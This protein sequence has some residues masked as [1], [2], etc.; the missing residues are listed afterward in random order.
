MPDIDALLEEMTLTEK[1]ALLGGAD[2]WHTS[3]VERLDVP[4]LK[5]TDG[6]NGA[7]GDAVLGSGTG[8]SACIPCGSALGATWDPALVEELGVLLG[9]EADTKAAHVLLAPT[10][11][12]HRHPLGGRNFECYSEDPELTGR[13]AIG[14]VRGVQS[15]GIATT[16]KHF[17]GNDS[18]FERNSIDSRIDER[19]LREIYLRPFELAL[20]DGGAWGVM[21]AYNRLNG[22]HCSE[23]HRLLT[24]ILRDEWG[25]DGFVISDWFASKA[26]A[27]TANAGMELEMPGP[28]SWYGTKLVEAVEAGDVDEHQV[29]ALARRMLV[30]IER[31]GAFA[32][33]KQRPEQAVDRPEHRV[34]CRRAA[35]EATVLLANNGVLPLTAS[36]LSSVAVIGPNADIA[37]IM[38]G[39]SANVR[40]HYRRTPLDELTERLPDTTVV[41]EPGC[42]TA[43]TIPEI[44][45]SSLRTADGE[46]GIVVE[47]VN[48]TAIT[49]LGDDFDDQIVARQVRDSTRLMSFGQ[50][51]DGVD[52][53][54]FGFRARAELIPKESGVHTFSLIQVG[55]T[56]VSIDD[57]VILDGL[58][59]P[60]PTGDAFFG[61]G[62][63]EVTADVD[64]EQGRPVRLLIEYS[65]AGAV[66]LNAANVGCRPPVPVDIIDRAVT[67]AAGADAA[68]VVVGTN[69]DWE[70][71]GHDREAMDLPGDQ[72]ELIR[73][74]AAANDRTVVVINAGSPVDVGWAV[75]V[76]AVVDCW[77]GGQGMAEGLADVLLGDADPGG[78]LPTTFPNRQQQAPSHL[79]YP[80][81]NGTVHYGEGVYVGY[82]GYDE[83]GTDPAFCFGHGLSYASFEWSE[84][85]VPTT[86]AVG[87]TVTVRL[88]ITNTSDRDGIE[89]VQ[90]YVA[91]VSPRLARPP[92]ELKAFAK[93]HLDAGQTTEVELVLDE[94][95][96]AYYDPGLAEGHKA[97]GFGAPTSDWGT[98]AGWR[99]D[100]GD[101]EIRFA[102]SSRDVVATRSIALA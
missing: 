101:Y 57:E 95:A 2:M 47:Y 52:M 53:N 34:V 71:E 41:F 70:T 20:L 45:S 39:G 14:F 18:E 8:S 12:I 87:D 67:A 65:S 79:T 36:D 86:A 75:D 46:A 68:I 17:V 3:G 30:A 40:P 60:L 64:L 58:S 80:G 27:E 15:R 77:F 38:G 42:M 29:N 63:A 98:D 28:P 19:A 73:R 26:T 100:P 78:R 99:T 4:G 97:M 55:G 90:V 56:R 48:T 5:V 9:E 16:P 81:E 35:T 89:V 7:R 54:G 94:R 96:F 62:S 1:V 22:T 32:D 83:L 6:P 50:A 66:I 74:V 23:N 51:V 37:Q 59:E 13:L 61:M 43:K 11:N 85:G 49:E 24:E 84:P 33:P 44:S 91:P 82:R 31:T 21:C 102:R 25:W 93:V 69:D 72:A 92:Q 10:I 88:G 76:A